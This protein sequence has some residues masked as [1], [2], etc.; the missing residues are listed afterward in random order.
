MA[1]PRG[2]YLSRPAWEDIT[3]LAP[4]LPSITE[5]AELVDIQRASLSGIIGGHTRASTDKA[6][7]IAAVV[8]VRVET[9]FPTLLPSVA[10]CEEVAA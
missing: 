7:R 4:N 9:L 2:H 6:K 5:M 3:K 1:R 10:E 8:G